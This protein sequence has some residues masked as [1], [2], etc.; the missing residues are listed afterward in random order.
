[1][2]GSLA[3]DHELA[4]FAADLG[5]FGDRH[6]TASGEELATGPHIFKDQGDDLVAVKGAELKILAM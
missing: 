5:F 4:D 1:V 3:H 6:S 2:R